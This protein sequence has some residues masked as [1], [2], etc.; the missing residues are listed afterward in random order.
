MFGELFL[1]ENTAYEYNS[2]PLPH[3]NIQGLNFSQIVSDL[4]STMCSR[5]A[6]KS[7]YLDIQQ[8]ISQFDKQIVRVI[9]VTYKP[10]YPLEEKVGLK[11]TNAQTGFSTGCYHW[12]TRT[13]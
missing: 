3:P 12:F 4:D 10:L 5:V 2:R 6:T 7:E 8:I 11:G 9:D 1:G 13:I